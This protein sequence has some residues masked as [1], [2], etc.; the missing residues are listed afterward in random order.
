[1]RQSAVFLFTLFSLI[2]ARD[3]YVDS[4][5]GNDDSVGTSP[6]K[7]WR[8]LEKISATIFLP[9]DNIYLRRGQHWTGN[10]Q[11]RGSGSE[12]NPITIGAYGDENGR[13]IIN[14][15]GYSGTHETPVGVVYIENEEFWVIRDLEVTNN[16]D[17]ERTYS[18]GILARNISGGALRH[19]H[20]KN[21]Y[22]HDIPVSNENN[23][24]TNKDKYLGG[25]RVKAFGES[26]SWWDGV[27]IENNVMVRPGRCGIATGAGFAHPDQTPYRPNLN[28][29]I[30]GNHI[31]YTEGDG[32]I[33][34]SALKPLIEHNV[35]AHCGGVT[36][37]S[38]GIWCWQTV[39]ALFQYNEAY[40]C[41]DPGS[42]GTGFDADYNCYGTIFQY[43]YS[44]DNEGGFMLV[45]EHKD[46]YPNKDIIIRYNISIND[47]QRIFK[48]NGGPSVEQ[49]LTVH[50]NLFILRE[51]GQS[52]SLVA[53]NF[54]NNIIYAP[55]DKMDWNIRVSEKSDYNCYFGPGT[56]PSEPHSIYE[57]P[58][59]VN[60]GFSDT[61]FAG[62]IGYRL[63]T[64][65]PCIDAGVAYD[66]AAGLKYD[67]QGTPLWESTPDM[68]PFEMPAP[69]AI[70]RNI[71]TP[72]TGTGT[73]NFSNWR[74]YVHFSSQSFHRKDRPG[75][76][77][78]GRR[79]SL[80]PK[81]PEASSIR[82]IPTD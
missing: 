17:N 61:G 59:F 43:N 68:G 81:N 26:P 54:Y 44:H 74:P 39:D 75:L 5:R 7:P 79:L 4:D 42:D 64:G 67:F 35:V 34:V 72:K 66:S 50:N 18:H 1:M 15:N 45:M 80:T 62:L 19:I 56:P 36:D 23:Q 60:P 25:I 57:D 29:V 33:A 63:V 73:R 48:G 49:N 40:G 11:L 77:C 38:V 52:A 14:G 2:G 12:G 53:T 22:L 21:C 58:L 3:Y 9:G 16:R 46:N 32:I 30:R 69:T 71:T 41:H 55:G 82:L 76:D 20:I 78:R 31:S 24:C 70:L 10:V 13:P 27:L 8:S 47:R 37:Y 51:S 65:S 28:V 6:Q